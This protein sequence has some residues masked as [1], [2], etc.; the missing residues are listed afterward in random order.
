MAASF[1]KIAL[2]TEET[3]HGL[4]ACSSQGLKSH[5]EVKTVWVQLHQMS[6]LLPVQPLA[7]EEKITDRIGFNS[8]AKLTM[9]NWAMHGTFPVRKIMCKSWTRACGWPFGCGF[10]KSHWNHWVIHRFWVAWLCRIATSVFILIIG[11]GRPKDYKSNLTGCSILCSTETGN[12][13]R[14]FEQEIW[15][16]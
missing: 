10:F 5:L 15:C 1:G 6:S 4:C 2:T 9:H 11:P 8:P 13:N 12:W 16:T 7:W 3:M 14:I